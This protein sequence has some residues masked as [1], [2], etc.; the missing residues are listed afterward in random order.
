M[1]MDCDYFRPAPFPPRSKQILF[2]GFLPHTPN[3]DAL[4]YFI[5]NEWPLIRR[6]DPEAQLAVI[7]EGA[8]N[9]LKGRM[10]DSGVEY[11]GYVEDL[12]EVYRQTRVYIAPVTSGGGIRTKIVEAMTAGVPVVCNSFAPLGLG[13]LPDH[14]VTI[15]DDPAESAAAILQ[16]LRDDDLWLRRR[17]AGRLL[18]ENCFSLERVGPRV[19]RRYVQFLEEAA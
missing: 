8:S 12:R 10:H 4:T 16:L 18:A 19:A 1:L 17:D 2:V 11:L 15:R 7:G 9:A 13:V 14:H 6:E 3:T 5:R